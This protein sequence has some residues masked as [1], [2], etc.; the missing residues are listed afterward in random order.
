M[1][2]YFTLRIHSP[3]IVNFLVRMQ[4]CQAKPQT[5]NGD[6]DKRAAV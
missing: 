3:Q 1:K 2:H 6:A 4:A 5:A